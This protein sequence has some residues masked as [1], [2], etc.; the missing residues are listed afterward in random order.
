[1]STFDGLPEGWAVWNEEAD[2]KAVLVYRP[3]VFDGDAFPPACLPTLSLTT[4]SPNRP[5]G[6][7]TTGP[8]NWH[9]LLFLEPDVRVR[10]PGVETTFER[11]DAAVAATVELTRRF[12]DGEIDLRA[13]YQLPRD[14]YL[15]ELEALT[16]RDA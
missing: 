8:T 11:Y 5:P 1:M 10:D 4:Q 7:T 12:A 3:D 13:C 6:E 15:D 2:G 14:A 9:V 16:G